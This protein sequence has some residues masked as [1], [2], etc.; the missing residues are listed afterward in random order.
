MQIKKLEYYDDEYKW[1]LE[2]VNFLPNLN[3]L[4]GVSGVGKTRILRAIYNLKSIANGASLNGVKWNVCFIANNNLEYTW[5][6]EFETRE[7]TISI[8]ETSEDDEQVKLINEQL[9]CNNE[10]VL[11]ERKDSEIIFNGSKTPKLSPFE[12]VVELLK[13]EDQIAPVK[14]S[15]DKI[16]LADSE[17]V[18][19]AW[20][21]P[22]SIFKKFEKASLSALQESGLPVPIKLSI[23]Y[24]TLPDEFNKI[25]EAFISVFPNV[26][27]IK[28]E[29]I[30]DDDIPIALSKL[31][32]EATT[33]SIKEKGIEDW[34]ENISS[35][36]LKTLM[37][38]SELY[39]APENCIILIDEFENSLGVNCLDS[40]T[41]LVL[42]NKKLQFIITS[43]HPYIINNVS[44]AYWKIVT[45]KAGLV[46]VKNS[47]DFHISESRQKAF[48]DL[49]NVLE[50]EADL[51]E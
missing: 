20:R 39:L 9:V 29:T 35:G 44:P 25:K 8:N 40:V 15:L 42:D 1:K 22:V 36:M 17:S 18:D 5:S 13:Q 10:T 26:S 50:D 34:I 43:H 32:K 2:E 12:S 21:L 33:V 11:I 4:V 37:Y 51:E 48:I 3:L 24:R 6:G 41:E 49:I 38:I 23:L 45:R 27:D 28:V 46:T 7:N 14:E 19:R 31:L 30:K 16:V 47:K